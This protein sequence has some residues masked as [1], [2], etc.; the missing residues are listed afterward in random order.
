MGRYE[1]A[2]NWCKTEG[3]LHFIDST[4]WVIVSLPVTAFYET[5]LAG[6]PDEISIKARALGVI[7][8]YIG[9]GKLIVYGRRRWREQFKINDESP[10][11]KQLIQDGVYNFFLH[12]IANP[13]IYSA[14]GCKNFREIAI[15]TSFACILA[16]VSG[17]ASG[18]TSDN[19]RDWMGYESSKRVPEFI[20]GQSR[21]TKKNLVGLI[22]LFSVTATAGVYYF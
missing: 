8:T 7:D 3:K 19:F 15:A 17:A 12:L 10:E 2:V 5:Q 11:A 18:F 13:I 4:A 21:R 1:R 16:L 6:I 9:L 14:L 20:N 22:S